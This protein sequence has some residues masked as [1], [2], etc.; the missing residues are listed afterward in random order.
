MADIAA[1]LNCA[2]SAEEIE[3]AI[4]SSSAINLAETAPSGSLSES[5]KVILKAA[6]ERVL[7][8]DT[9][10]TT[11][12][13][14]RRIKRFQ[15]SLYTA[16][17]DVEP[18]SSSAHVVPEVKRRLC[19]ED[20]IS[21]LKG[22]KSHHDLTREMNNLFLP[23][24]EDGGIRSIHFVK[25]RCPMKDVL[26]SLV[27]TTGMTNKPLRRRVS[28]LIFVL[29]TDEEQAQELAVVKAK[30][31]M[32]SVRNLTQ[33]KTRAAV[34]DTHIAANI[35]PEPE[36]VQTVLTKFEAAKYLADCISSIRSAK[37]PA[38]VEKAIN[39]LPSGGYGD[40][41]TLRDLLNS[42][43][44]NPDLVNN[45]KLRRR[46]KRLIETLAASG[47]AAP[48][49]SPTAVEPQS[50]AP[51]IVKVERIATPNGLLKPLAY[52]SVKERHQP[53]LIPSTDAAVVVP[54]IPPVRVITGSFCQSLELLTAASSSSHVEEAIADLCNE[55]S[56]GEAD[57]EAVRARLEQLNQD[58]M[59]VN[60]SKLRRRVKRL[61]DMLTP[62]LPAPQPNIPAVVSPSKEPTSV[63]T[64]NK[65]KLSV[66]KEDTKNPP[67]GPS[68]D[69]V[70]AEAIA[71]QTSDQL[72]SALSTVNA[73]SGSC[74]SRRTLKRIL[75]RVMRDDSSMLGQMTAQNRR[76]M[77]R[78]AD[79]LSPRTAL[80]LS[81][82][83]ISSNEVS[84]TIAAHVC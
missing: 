46:V 44:E 61:I 68:L 56:G 32:A 3:N 8:N 66:K 59:I 51:S 11:A 82:T 78:V 45:A 79:I 27:I 25:Y 12:K 9:I 35:S 58:E 76:K 33:K 4:T 69:G 41:E 80:A 31:A 34:I 21:A 57:R 19:A 28:R 43:T 37:N 63:A 49:P 83:Q 71:A 84:S 6:L 70:I 60:N 77:R 52:L 1:A 38:D 15:Q 47:S 14:R 22:C 50:E 40:S 53:L 26:K 18:Y 74:S 23:S 72:T 30:A 2:T 5:A 81:G 64:K 36:I 16:T 67:P 48:L 13:L 29:S 75:E 73:E 55:S 42:I 54:V 20:S 39:A 62:E 10:P 65:K 17:D 7:D 24:E